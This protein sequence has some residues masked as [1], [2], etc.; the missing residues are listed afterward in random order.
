MRHKVAGWKLGRNTA[1]RRSLLRNLVTSLIVEE[2]IETTIPKAKAMRPHVEKMITL[3]KRGD[4]AARRLAAAY[5]MTKESVTKLFDT[6]APRFGD[7]NG[8]YL[9]IVRTTWQKGDGAEKAFVELLGSEK[10]LDEKREKRAEARAKRV[11]EAKKAME[12]ADAQAQ[13]RSRSP[14]PRERRETEEKRFD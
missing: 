8:G 12:E 6:I 2:R 13:G 1:H 3:G 7:R 11:A 9:R 4:L 5:L 14:R 10:V